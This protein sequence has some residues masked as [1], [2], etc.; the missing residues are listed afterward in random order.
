MSNKVCLMYSDQLS[1]YNYGCNHPMKPERISMVY[2]LI[3]ELNLAHKFD[4]EEAKECTNEDL[5]KFHNLEY[6]DFM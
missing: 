6:I 2:D 5:E 3:K 4:I 1:T